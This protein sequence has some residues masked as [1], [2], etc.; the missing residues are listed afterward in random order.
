MKNAGPFSLVKNKIAV[1]LPTLCHG[2]LAFVRTTT[3][4]Y[5]LCLSMTDCLTIHELMNSENTKERF[6]IDLGH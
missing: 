2:D 4:S 3:V 6:R 1:N 5:A